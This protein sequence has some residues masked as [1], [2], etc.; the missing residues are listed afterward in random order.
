MVFLGE[1]FS[2]DSRKR[3]Q[4]AVKRVISLK[5]T[6]EKDGSKLF[7]PNIASLFSHVGTRSM[8]VSSDLITKNGFQVI[9]AQKESLGFP[10]TPRSKPEK[11]LS[12]QK[13]ISIDEP[14]VY[15]IGNPNRQEASFKRRKAISSVDSEGIHIQP[16]GLA[17]T[18]KVRSV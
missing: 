9:Q 16:N 11:S 7:E 17:D 4:K 10:Y 13:S 2:K 18:P 3:M 1:E 8:M 12:E 14:Q 15:A 6:I 5:K